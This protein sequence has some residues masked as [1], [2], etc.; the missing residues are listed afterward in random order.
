MNTDI[1]PENVNPVDSEDFNADI[2][3][4][5]LMDTPDDQTGADVTAELPI[6][7]DLEDAAAPDSTDSADDEPKTPKSSSSLKRK[8][9]A[10][11]VALAIVAALGIGLSLNHEAVNIPDN[12]PVASI[13]GGKEDAKTYP[14]S[15]TLEAGGWN[16]GDGEFSYEVVDANGK[17]AAKGDIV[18]GKEASVDLPKGAYALN[19]TSIP[20]AK[21]GKTT[22]LVPDAVDFVVEGEGASVKVSLAKVDMTDDAAVEAAIEK[23]PEEER[24]AAKKL[25]EA[26]RENP[27]ASTVSAP[28]SK[29]SSSTVQQAAASKPS[30][31]NSNKNDSKP[32]SKP[33]GSGSNKNDSKPSSGS[34]KDDKPAPKPSA[35][36]NS[37][38]NSGNGSGSETPKPSKPAEPEKVWG[39]VTPA[40]D[41]QVYHPAVTHTETQKQKVG[42]QYMADDGTLF[43]SEDAC[44]EYCWDNG[45]QYSC[46]PK[47]Q[48]VTVTVTDQ[49]A[50]TE[51]VHHDAVY[52]WVTK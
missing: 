31:S 22:W 30:G 51:T 33:S 15:V 42:V 19:V 14:A 38:G 6:A 16:E 45:L 1:N 24:A 39:I 2:E 10:G 47:Y 28:V 7:K 34:N 12:A 4:T 43:D 50:W 29:P 17:S 26:K 18:P 52:G 35:P 25:I 5:Q 48:E 37:G 21:D 32:A 44:S 46:L 9:V 13:V 36:G 23:L 20:T 3:D 49:A 11:G 40:W 8:L 41:E 27:D